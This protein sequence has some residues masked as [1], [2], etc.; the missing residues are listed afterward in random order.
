MISARLL[1][2]IWIPNV[3]PSISRVDGRRYVLYSILRPKEWDTKK[4]WR[5]NRHTLTFNNK[6]KDAAHKESINAHCTIVLALF[7]TEDSSFD[8]FSFIEKDSVNFYFQW[9]KWPFKFDIPLPILFD[10]IACLA[11]FA[12]P[13]PNWF[14]FDQCDDNNNTE[15]RV[16]TWINTMKKK[17][18]YKKNVNNNNNQFDKFLWCFWYCVSSAIPLEDWVPFF[19]FFF[20]ISLLLWLAKH[21]ISD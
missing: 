14:R 18:K 15:Q 16:K 11:C 5:S 10:F 20:L 2:L 12:C 17:K 21:K 19:S 4:R 13:M 9:I 7:R 8:C 1:W 6:Q 3:E